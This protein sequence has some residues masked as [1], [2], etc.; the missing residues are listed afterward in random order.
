[1][2]E[3]QQVSISTIIYKQLF[4]KKCFIAYMWLQFEFVIF[5]QK[6]ISAKAARCNFH[7]QLS[8]F[9]AS[10]FTHSKEC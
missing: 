10:K 7:Q 8:S 4:R 9:S 5:F 3:Q 6:E 1:M 2:L